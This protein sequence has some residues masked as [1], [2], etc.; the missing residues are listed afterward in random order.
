MSLQL[1]FSKKNFDIYY[2]INQCLTDSIFVTGT[3]DISRSIPAELNPIL[4]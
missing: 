3:K 1:L 2:N 4:N